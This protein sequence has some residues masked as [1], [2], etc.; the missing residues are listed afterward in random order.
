MNAQEKI[1]SIIKIIN[2]QE[3]DLCPYCFKPFEKFKDKSGKIT[4]GCYDH[5]EGEI[6]LAIDDY[7]INIVNIIKYGEVKKIENY[8]RFW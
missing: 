7:Y 8:K 3:N 1:E 4:E 6:I 5:T 2:A